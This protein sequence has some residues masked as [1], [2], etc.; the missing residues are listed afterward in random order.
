MTWRH[1]ISHG[2]LTGI[3]VRAIHLIYF[4][5]R[6]LELGYVKLNKENHLKWH[7]EAS[8]GSAQSVYCRPQQEQMY[9][10]L[11]AG[12]TY[13]I[14]SEG[15]KKNFS[16]PRDRLSQQEDTTIQPLRILHHLKYSLPP[17]HFRSK[18]RLSNS[19]FSP[20]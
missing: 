11:P 9:L 7:P 15:G 1:V 12:E 19:S 3:S 8:R 5:A 14:T 4:Y 17:M 6:N 16:L 13:L 10:A 2:Y 18:Y 20:L